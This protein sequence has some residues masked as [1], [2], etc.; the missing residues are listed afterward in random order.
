M[1]AANQNTLGKRKDTVVNSEQTREFV[2]N[3]ATYDLRDAV[4]RSAAEVGPEVDEL[5]LPV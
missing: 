5:Q 2:Y 3:L 1:F 4:N